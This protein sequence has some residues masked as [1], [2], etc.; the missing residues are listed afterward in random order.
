MFLSYKDPCL[1]EGISEWNSTVKKSKEPL[2][3]TFQEYCSNIQNFFTNN[4]HGSIIEPISHLAQLLKNENIPYIAILNHYEIPSILFHY[5][6]DD[7]FSF[8]QTYSI[9]CLINISAIDNSE[10][11]FDSEMNCSII[12]NLL[13]R[14]TDKEKLNHILLLINNLIKFCNTRINSYFLQNHIIEIFL[15]ISNKGTNS[16]ILVNLLDSILVLSTEQLSP[17]CVLNIYR[18]FSYIQNRSN[19]HLTYIIKI[20]NNLII[21]NSIQFEEFDNFQVYNMIKVVIS[22][23]DNGLNELTSIA[24]KAIA[25]L[26]DAFHC[27]ELFDFGNILRLMGLETTTSKEEECIYNVEKAFLSYITIDKEKIHKLLTEDNIRIFLY[28]LQNS[29]ISCKLVLIKIFNQFVTEMISDHFQLVFLV[30]NDLS[31]FNEIA[32]AMQTEDVEVVFESLVLINSIFDKSVAFNAIQQ[33]RTSF[34]GFFDP[35][36]FDLFESLENEQ[37]SQLAEKLKSYVFA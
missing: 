28:L 35:S 19:K 5:L 29:K 2:F 27:T 30:E 25:R 1:E 7:A 23:H 16:D 9:N 4:D 14:A 26:I 13:K 10:L 17:E 32:Q 11:I 22:N 12:I 3:V 15:V 8:Q 37:I 24:C 33:C 36:Y 21:T 20:I 18:L 6:S 34:Q 31:L